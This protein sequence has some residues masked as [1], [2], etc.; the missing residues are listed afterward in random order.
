MGFLD[1]LTNLNPEQNQGLL[2]AA[3]QMLSLSGPS[4]MPIGLGQ[5][6]AGGL[7]GYQEGLTQAQKRKLEEEQARQMAQLRDLQIQTGTG[8]LQAQQQARAQQQAID[9]AAQGAVSGGQFDQNAFLQQVRGISPLKAMELERQMAKAGPEFDTKPQTAIGPD[10][11]P[12]QYIIA[13]NGQVQRLDGILPRDELK[14]ANLGGRDVAYNPYALQ[15]GQS[16]QR[17]Q[18][19]DSAASVAA[20]LRGQNLTDARSRETNAI[21]KIPAGYR[22]LP[23]GSLQAIPGGPADPSMSKEANQRTTD[24]R[25]VLGILDQAEPLIKQSTSSYAGAGIDQLARVAGYSTLGA[26]AGSELQVL[27]GALISKMPKMSGPQSD[28]DVQLYRE[29]AGRIGDTTL[30]ADQRLAAVRQVRAL[31]EKYLGNQGRQSQ[32]AKRSAIK[33]QVQDGYRFKGGDPS[34]QENW[35]KI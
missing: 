29:M 14:L 10:G 21:G 35:E 34:K 23:D 1:Q 27:Q 24:A 8:D 16:F 20:T 30:P 6:L 28:K 25:D 11:K 9:A 13:K 26:A 12:F 4:R 18:T 2:A 7:G 3:T 31:N 33:G 5:V 32:P 17:T 15:E 22:Q 19:P